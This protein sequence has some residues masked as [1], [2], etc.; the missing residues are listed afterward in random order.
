MAL[1]LTRRRTIPAAY[2]A[3]VRKSARKLVK[4]L[5]LAEREL[6]ILLTDEGEM[7]ELNRAYR[8]KDRPTDVLSFSQSEGPAVPRSSLLGDLVLCPPVAERQA[9]ERG[10]P[11]AHELDILL[12][13]GLLHLLGHDHERVPRKKRE[14][15]FEEQARLVA[16]LSAPR[17]KARW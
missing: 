2:A 11:T 4:L 14:A 1:S 7:Q 16:L 8:G 12:V 5:D 3:Q 6:S 15:M 9:K 17:P 10:H 13:H